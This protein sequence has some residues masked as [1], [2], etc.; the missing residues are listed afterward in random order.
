MINKILISEKM[1]ISRNLAGWYSKPVNTV[2]ENPEQS[3]R[4]HITYTNNKLL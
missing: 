4:N 3:S 1:S 2:P